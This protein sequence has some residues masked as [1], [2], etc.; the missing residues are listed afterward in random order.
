[1]IFRDEED[2]D[3]LYGTGGSGLSKLERDALIGQGIDL[4]SRG[5]LGEAIDCY[6]KAIKGGLNIAAAHF[7]IGLL[8]LETGRTDDAKQSL[9]LAAKDAAYREAVE[10]ALA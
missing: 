6:E 2:E 9:M 7:T 5:Q 3:L 8:Y 1:E 4:Q 10:T